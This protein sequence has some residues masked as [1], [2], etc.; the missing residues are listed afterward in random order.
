MTRET[1]IGLL[2]GL[3]FIIV[4]GI[5][6]SDHLTTSTEPPQAPLAQAGNS[7]RAAVGQPAS[8]NPPITTVG[9]HR[10]VAPTQVVTTREEMVKPQASQIIKI[11]PTAEQP[12]AGVP[13]GVE[14][15]GITN[16]QNTPV[17]QGVPTELAQAAR[18]HN[19]EVV[20]VGREPSQPMDNT[21]NGQKIYVAQ[22]GD[23]LTKIAAKFLG[24]GGKANRE[25]IIRANPSLRENPNKIIVGRSYTIPTAGASPTVTT[26]S[27]AASP[28]PAAGLGLRPLPETASAEASSAN[29]YTV[30]PGDNLTKIAIEQLDDRKAVASIISLNKDVLK[31]GTTI[32]AGMKL[33]LPGKSIASAR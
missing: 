17:P 23:T 11:A 4:I 13:N 15:A 27:S 5:L 6:L 18:Q 10:N 7:V 26:V 31:G 22:P 8:A 3:A 19:E 9:E 32:R 21:V 25:A 20:L 2:V 30:K 12:I 28:D 1:K 14:V 16:G 33:R 24:S 29:V